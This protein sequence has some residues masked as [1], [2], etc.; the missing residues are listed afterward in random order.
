MFKRSLALLV[1]SAL[2]LAAMPAIAQDEE[3]RL[4]ELQADNAVIF[5]STE[6]EKPAGNELGGIKAVYLSGDVLLTEGSR[7]LR[8]EEIYYNFDA[9]KALAVK[10][11]MRTFD[12]TRGIPIYIK[13]IRLRQLAEDKF[14]AEQTF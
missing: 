14:G 5:R 1:L 4:L 10:A 11:I 12:E 7:T 8:A 6:D 3:G 13:A 9:K 2:A